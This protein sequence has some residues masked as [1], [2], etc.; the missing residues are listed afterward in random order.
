MFSIAIIGVSNTRVLIH[1]S[2]C[3]AVGERSA[4]SCSGMCQGEL[5]VPP[6]RPQEVRY[7]WQRFLPLRFAIPSIRELLLGVARDDPFSADV[8]VFIK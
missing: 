3:T 4:M 7:V 8:R 6:V 1:S 2:N 5:G